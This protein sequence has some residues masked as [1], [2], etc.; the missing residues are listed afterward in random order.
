M[1]SDS[2]TLSA[3]VIGV[4]SLGRY[5]AQKYAALPGVALYGVADLDESR[6]HAVS[7]K[8]DR[9]Q[10]PAGNLDTLFRFFVLCP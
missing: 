4:G 5:H 2:K 10:G 6:A 1:A 7:R 3:G 9:R 8:R